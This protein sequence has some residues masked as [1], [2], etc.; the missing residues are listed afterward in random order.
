MIGTGIGKR[1]SRRTKEE[2]EFGTLAISATDSMAMQRLLET[3]GAVQG[4]R[5]D[6]VID[7]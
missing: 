2:M 3:K 4:R 1:D 6:I 7:D 5:M